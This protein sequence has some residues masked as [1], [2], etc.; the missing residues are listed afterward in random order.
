MTS[1]NQE[2]EVKFYL[3]NFAALESRLNEAGAVLHSPRVL[4]KN[5][6]LDTADGSL[7]RTSRMLRLRQDAVSRVTFKGPSEIQDGARL[8][9]ELEFVVSNIDTAQ[10]LF[11]ALG[12][13]VVVLYE[14][15]RTTYK[16]DGVEVTLDEI[17]Y[18]KFCEIEGPNGLAIRRTAERLGFKWGDRIN[19]S[20]L[21]MFERMRSALGFTFRDLTFD[22]FK[23]IE[24]WYEDL[25][26]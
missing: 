12:H 20:Y 18:G 26:L 23:G 21:M 19:D 22:N 24:V 25:G 13:Q 10:S 8:R 11:E 15:Y 9:Q 14:K 1:N 17:P 16:L 2:I 4:E 5:I 7:S 6:R 3:D